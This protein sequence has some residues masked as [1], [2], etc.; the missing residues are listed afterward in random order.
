M[1]GN[2]PFINL[3]TEVECVPGHRVAALET[4]ALTL[5]VWCRFTEAY[6]R[7][8]VLGAFLLAAGLSCGDRDSKAQRDGH[9]QR[10]RDSIL[11]ASKLPGAQGVRGAL[12]ASDSAAARRAREDAAQQE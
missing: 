10:E 5:S 11:G 1:G 2:R 4:R 9:T 7:V 12:K 3:P 8:L 6:M